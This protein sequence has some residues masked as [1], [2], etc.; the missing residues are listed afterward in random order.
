MAKMWI[1]SGQG[2]KK[3]RSAMQEIDDLSE[4][5]GEK[6]W[7]HQPHCRCAGKIMGG[8]GN[9]MS[10]K[11]TPLITNILNHQAQNYSNILQI[12]Y[13]NLVHVRERHQS[14]IWQCNLE[15]GDHRE[16]VAEA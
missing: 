13:S 12:T 9:Q 15:N 1:W 11:L 4:F 8:D 7:K 14:Y 5:S 3:A 2:R 10:K 16:V 6:S